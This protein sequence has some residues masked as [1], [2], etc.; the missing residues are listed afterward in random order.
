ML[1]N[2]ISATGGTTP[3]DLAS[4]VTETAGIVNQTAQLYRRGQ[5]RYVPTPASCSAKST[6]GSFTRLFSASGYGAR[7]RAIS[8]Y[9]QDNWKVTPKLTLDLGLRYD[10]YPQRQ[11]SAGHASF[12]DPNLANPVTGLQWRPELHGTRRGHLQLRHARQELLQ[13]HWA[14]PWRGLSA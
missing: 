12:F 4:A 9:V 6:Q 14:A 7:F 10:F 8:P 13:E 11:G 5:H 2:T 1:Y 3:I